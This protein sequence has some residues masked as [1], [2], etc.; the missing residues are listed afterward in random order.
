MSACISE[1]KII[2]PQR[3]KATIKHFYHIKMIILLN[4]WLYYATDCIYEQNLCV[5]FQPN[6]LEKHCGFQ[7]GEPD[8]SFCG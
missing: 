1:R 4:N 8:T 6:S 2:L 3:C 5:G 7:D